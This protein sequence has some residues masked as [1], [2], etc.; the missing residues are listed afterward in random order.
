[1]TLRRQTKQGV[2]EAI[3]A[4][5]QPTIPRNGLGLTLRNGRR[6][7]GL[8]DA[9]GNLSAAGTY[10]YRQTDQTPPQRFDYNQVP[11]RTGRS[12]TIR[13]LDGSRKTVQR[14]DPV[15]KEFKP[16]LLGKKFYSR[17]TDRITVLFPVFVD[18]TR[19]NGSVYSRRD[20]LPS[21][22]TSLGEL[23]VSAALSQAEQEREIRRL[24]RVWMDAQP[25]MGEERILLAGY[26][27]HR[28]DPSRQIQY[29]KLSH[30]AAAEPEAIMNRPLMAGDPWSFGFPGVCQEAAEATDGQCVPHQL[31]KC[32]R[33]KGQ[34]EGHPFN[35]QQI[36]E[37]LWNASLELYEDDDPELLECPGFSAAAIRRVCEAHSIPFCVCHGTNKLD[38]F[39]P[40]TSKYEN[41]VC[42]VWGDHLYCVADKAIAA[43]LVKAPPAEA[44]LDWCLAPIQRRPRRGADVTSWELYT[45]T[46]PPANSTQGTSTRRER[47]CMRRASARS[48]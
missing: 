34:P 10:F 46:W 22:A 28:D 8:V 38:S 4:G 33:L 30:N 9:A 43:A 39:T 20:F 29:N 21:T 11:E 3:A 37:E 31:A 40:M 6:R 27:T 7:T 1:M 5:S 26:E 2:D 35:E 41:L 24:A 32:I 17:R 23:Q 15:S 47:N 45:H 42:H 14:F 25:L 18:I 13:V 12:L 19:T 36:A 16:T 48:W 44:P